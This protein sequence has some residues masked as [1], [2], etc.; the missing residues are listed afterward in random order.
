MCTSSDTHYK[1]RHLL[2]E[3]TDCSKNEQDADCPWYVK[4]FEILL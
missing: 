4:N 2:A 1:T 3:I